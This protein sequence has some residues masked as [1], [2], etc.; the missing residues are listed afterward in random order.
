MSI[1]FG[2]QAFQEPLGLSSA[3]RVVN[4]LPGTTTYYGANEV[5]V[6]IVAWSPNLQR[7]A[8]CVPEDWNKGGATLAHTIPVVWY[9]VARSGY[10]KP[11]RN[12]CM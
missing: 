11:Y 6:G 1:Y 3:W 7:P 12:S 4:R 5:A 10:F 2:H 8:A 9:E